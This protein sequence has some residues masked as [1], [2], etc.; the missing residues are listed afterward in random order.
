MLD[1]FSF[2]SHWLGSSTTTHSQSPVATSSFKDAVLAA[3]ANFVGTILGTGKKLQQSRPTRAEVSGEKGENGAP[4]EIRTPDLLLRRLS[5]PRCTTQN[6]RFAIAQELH[7][8][9]IS[10]ELNTFLNTQ[11]GS[12]LLQ[13]PHHPHT[14][15]KTSAGHPDRCRR[16]I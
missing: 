14:K 2:G 13:N 8:A 9:A 16:A 11:P 4:G 7:N 12:N 5:K 10:R 3:V 15:N 1:V 6:H